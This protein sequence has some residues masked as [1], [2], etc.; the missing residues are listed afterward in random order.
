MRQAAQHA[1]EQPAGQ[2]APRVPCRRPLTGWGRT[3]PSVAQVV[4]PPGVDD[5]ARL[6]ATRP[7]RGV[8]ARG[9]GRSYGDAAQNA[10]GLVLEIAGLDGIGPVDPATGLVTCGGGVSLDRLIRTVLPQGWFVP[11]TPGTRQVTVG[12]TIAADVHGKNH[13]RD[14]SISA[15]LD[16]LVLL[17]GRGDLHTLTP[18]DDLFWAVPGGMGL[19]GIVVAATLR[20]IPVRSGLMSVDTIRTDSLEETMEALA[21]ADRTHRYSVAWVDCLTPGAR[22]GRGIVTAGDHADHG[23]EPS[24]RGDPDVRAALPAGR[25]GVPRWAPPAP[26]N[27]LTVRF[28]NAVYHR[29]P[30]ARRSVEP[31]GSFF[32][33]LD[34]VAAWNR[35]YGARGFVQHQLTVRD[36]ETVRR[37]VGLFARHRAPTFLCVLKRFGAAGPAPLS[38]P[39]PGWTLAV[40]LPV[41]DGIGA[42]LD[43]VDAEVIS[44]GGRVYLAK[45][46]RLA[47]WAVAR[48]YPRLDEWRGLRDRLDPDHVFASDL[49]RRLGL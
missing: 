20:L 9:L 8:I 11:V 1:A 31:L 13:H 12:G 26:L 30:R 39:Q 14:G 32:H 49:S 36:P 22:L 45:D 21:A 28:F 16:S 4:A 29:A 18:G 41:S 10:G 3:A 17:D 42:M 37:V 48:M 35:L 24:P 19:T 46:A 33:P 25:L 15:H 23:A 6:I 34:V 43:E 2:P 7:P 38:F 47:P 40:D 5:L 27:P 44:A